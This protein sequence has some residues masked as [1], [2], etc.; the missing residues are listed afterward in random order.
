MRANYRPVIQL[1]EHALD[2]AKHGNIEYVKHVI[3]QVLRSLR[4]L[5]RREQE[6]DERMRKHAQF[7]EE[8]PDAFD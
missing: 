2:S 4:M 1:L 8:N 7:M 5:E 3:E 6:E